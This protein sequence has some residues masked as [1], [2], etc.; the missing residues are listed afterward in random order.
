[1]L[2]VTQILAAKPSGVRTVEVSLTVYA[3]VT[4]LASHQIGALVVVDADQP[5]IDAYDVAGAD[6]FE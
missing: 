5:A 3:A 2:S 4:L 6:A 1:M